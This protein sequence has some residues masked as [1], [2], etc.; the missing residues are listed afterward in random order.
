MVIFNEHLL[1]TDLTVTAYM[2]LGDSINPRH[3]QA[4]YSSLPAYTIARCPLCQAENI[5]RIDTYSVRY[6]PG[7]NYSGGRAVGSNEAIVHHCEHMALVQP[8][9]NFHGLVPSEAKKSLEREFGPEVPHVIGYLL[10]E[11]TCLAVIHALPVCRIEGE[12]FVPRYTMFL[13]SYFS[14]QR[15]EDTRKQVVRRANLHFSCE[16]PVDIFAQ[17]PDGTEHWWNLREWVAK[18]LLYWVD[19]NDPGL[20]LM[21]GDVQ[22]F[23][24]GEIAGRRYPYLGFVSTQEQPGASRDEFGGQKPRIKDFERFGDT[25]GITW[26]N[27]LERGFRFQPDSYVAYY[28]LPPDDLVG[29]GHSVQISARD[30]KR[31]FLRRD[32]ESEL[33]EV[34]L[35]VAYAPGERT[36][37]LTDNEAEAARWVRDA[38]ALLR[39]IKRI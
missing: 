19:G 2:A 6:W 26:H 31:F 10:E 16:V 18:G 32:E 22:A 5:E 9:I 8:F 34:V 27:I 35:E 3:R 7:V 20:G 11:G 13:V 12:R 37:G 17:P 39:S 25:L 15:P 23:P 21:T 4:Y 28:Y 1:K 36:L 30:M 29:P 14:Q 33:I 38:D 24:Y